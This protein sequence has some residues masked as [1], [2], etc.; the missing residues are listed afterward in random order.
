MSARGLVGIQLLLT[1]THPFLNVN[2][3]IKV[4]YIYK[5]YELL[6]LV[7]IFLLGCSVCILQ[8]P[9]YLHISSIL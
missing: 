1:R 9:G 7:D 5:Q 4:K 6:V 3:L 8:N 2:M